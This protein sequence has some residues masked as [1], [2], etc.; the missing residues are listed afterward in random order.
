MGVAGTP[1]LKTE[2]PPSRGS[3]FIY[4]WCAATIRAAM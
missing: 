3:I 1:K 2:P 4:P